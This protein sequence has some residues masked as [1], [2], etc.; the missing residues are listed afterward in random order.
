MNKQKKIIVVLIVVAVAMVA[1]LF[2]YGIWKKYAKKETVNEGEAEVYEDSSYITYK[3]KKYEYNHSL[4]N[5]LFM[6]VDKPE[7][8]E[9]TQVGQG[10]QADTLILMSMNRDNKTTTLLQI[11]RDVMTDID[12]YDMNGTY[13]STEKGQISLQYAYGDGKKK[14]C[15]MTMKAVSDLLYEVPVDSYL[16]MSVDGIAEITTLMGG[17][18]LTVPKDYT[19]IDPTFREGE[20]IVLAGEQAEKYVRYRD[21]EVTGSNIGRMERQEQFMLAL[22]R[23]MQG[24]DTGWYQQLLQETQEYLTMDLSVEE[25]DYM[26]SYQM[27]GEIEKIPGKMQ[28]G[29]E[30]DEF[31]VD[32][33]KLQDLIIKLFYKPVE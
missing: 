13:L 12:I 31:I 30:H 28:A 24:K 2:G 21:V 7:R 19:D 33:E 18:S 27:I 29:T 17:V 23:Q 1:S 8:M 25:V 15:R 20:T 11:P 14:S 26:K 32:N 9:E 4:K 3:G 16:A 6:G 5:I 22:A 10:G